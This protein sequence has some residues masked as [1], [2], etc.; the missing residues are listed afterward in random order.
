MK[1][2]L[3]LF[4]CLSNLW[5]FSFS[6]PI[7]LAES[8]N[9]IVIE[10]LQANEKKDLVLSWAK[11][12][13]PNFTKEEI[14]LCFSKLVYSSEWTT[15][16]KLVSGAGFDQTAIFIDS[17]GGV[18]ASWKDQNKLF[19]YEE[20]QEPSGVKI[21]VKKQSLKGSR[22]IQ[23]LFKDQIC[24]VKE[25]KIEGST[26]YL[27][28]WASKDLEFEPLLQLNPSEEYVNN[29]LKLFQNNEDRFLVFEKKSKSSSWAFWKN[30][31]KKRSLELSWYEKEACSSS[32]PILEDLSSQEIKQLEGKVNDQGNA[33]LCWSS[34]KE[35]NGEILNTIQAVT[36]SKEGVSS[37][38]DLFVSSDL[39][40]DKM[41]AIDHE[42][43]SLILFERSSNQISAAYKPVDEDWIF[44]ENIFPESPEDLTV[45]GLVP[46]L[47]GHFVL[48]CLTIGDGTTDVSLSTFSTRTQTFSGLSFIPK[49]IK[50]ITMKAK[51][52]ITG[53]GKGGICY[54]NAIV[55]YPSRVEGVDV[56]LEKSSIEVV[57]FTY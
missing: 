56:D 18:V 2:I 44:F 51:P 34:I 21:S 43:N 35:E 4:F 46:G 20:N 47:D 42:G 27:P 29:T 7:T 48:A 23:A 33:V 50:S 1:H 24:R 19:Y 54:E 55:H 45:T 14:G 11:L 37:P 52:F 5:S 8:S 25:E 38:S 13:Y 32:Q 17:Q 57:N 15:P 36:L 41:L 3:I 22:P 30:P 53:E 6:D 16:E 31:I 39:G 10:D 28:Y 26:Q 9:I 49:K 40:P 12:P